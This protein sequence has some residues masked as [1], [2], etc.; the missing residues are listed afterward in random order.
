MKVRPWHI[1]SC[2]VLVLSIGVLFT[3]QPVAAPPDQQSDSP[4][5]EAE[6]SPGSALPDRILEQRFAYFPDQYVNQ[7]KEPAAPIATF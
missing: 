2:V 1:G 7:A 3:F 6:Q 5:R 4:Q